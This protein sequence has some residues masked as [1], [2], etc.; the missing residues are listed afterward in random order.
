LGEQAR[1][2]Q[3]MNLF[4]VASKRVEDQNAHRDATMK[5]FLFSIQK[6]SPEHK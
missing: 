1:S 2:Q 4:Q 6:E 3:E 5:T